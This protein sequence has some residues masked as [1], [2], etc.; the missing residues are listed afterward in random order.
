MAASARLAASR[1]QK[2]A[3]IEQQFGTFFNDN[4]NKPASAYIKTTPGWSVTY[5]NENNTVT[6]GIN[7]LNQ[8]DGPT[9][10]C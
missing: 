7:L 1:V 4:F 3:V 2:I 8:Y 6:T 9:T 5:G 10:A